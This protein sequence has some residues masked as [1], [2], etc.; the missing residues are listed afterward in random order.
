MFSIPVE[1]HTDLAFNCLT[2]FAGNLSSE[3]VNNEAIGRKKTCIIVSVYTYMIII[4]NNYYYE[5]SYSIF[6]MSVCQWPKQ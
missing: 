1:L 5:C 2:H 4:R 3:E 6:C